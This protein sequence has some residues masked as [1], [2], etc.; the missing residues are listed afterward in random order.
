MY[1][2]GFGSRV[3]G[4]DQVGIGCQF[5]PFQPSKDMRAAT[6]VLERHELVDSS[7]GRVRFE[8][9]VTEELDRLYAA[10]LRLTRNR[11]AAED[12]VQETFLRAWRSFHTFE[13]GTN[14][15]AWFYKILVNAHIDSYRRASREPDVVD[16]EDVGDYYLY[17]KVHGSEELRRTGNPED[18]F[19]SSLM[20][21]DVK[22]ALEQ[23]PVR[24]RLPVILADVEQFSRMEVAEILG[25]PFGTVMSRLHRGRRY[26]QRA[27]WN[28]GRR[29]GYVK[30][31]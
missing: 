18:A 15:H 17:S 11:T 9:L 6:L 20:D 10:A 25:I 29:A 19:F 24:F 3:Q 14:A 7:E 26:L 30:E 12:L 21:A 13:V 31:R 4:P 28:Y 27:L 22:H 8:H 2:Q 16:Q 23:L 5:H 1:A